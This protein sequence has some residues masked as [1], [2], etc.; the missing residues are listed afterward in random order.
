MWPILDG[1]PAPSDYTLACS[2]SHTY[3]RAHKL[4]HTQTSQ[5]HSPQRP[6]RC[7][8]FVSMHQRP[9][10]APSP[11][12][13]SA[14][15]SLAQSI[16]APPHL[17]LSRLHY[18]LCPIHPLLPPPT[19]NLSFCPLF[20]VFIFPTQFVFSLRSVSPTALSRTSWWM[21]NLVVLY[22]AILVH[23]Q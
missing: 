12:L 10:A 20:E 5:T 9:N 14:C 3:T 11:P 18:C 16:R 13:S 22:P 2:I 17:P 6:L 4:T 23:V 15:S 1:N 8:W 21:S 7:K 19:H